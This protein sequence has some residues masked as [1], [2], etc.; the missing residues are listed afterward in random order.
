MRREWRRTDIKAHLQWAFRHCVG[1]WQVACVI[2]HMEYSLHCTVQLDTFG[3]HAAQLYS[4]QL[5]RKN[6]NN[7]FEYSFII[8]H[9]AGVVVC[10]KRSLVWYNFDPST[11]PPVTGSV[12][13][14]LHIFN[15]SPD[16]AGGTMCMLQIRTLSHQYQ[17]LLCQVGVL[18]NTRETP[19]TPHQHHAQQLLRFACNCC[20]NLTVCDV[21]PSG[22]QQYKT[23]SAPSLLYLEPICTANKSSRRLPE[24][25]TAVPACPGSA[26]Q[27]II[28]PS[29]RPHT[30]P[31]L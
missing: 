15:S 1:R 19:Q 26:V 7:W 24:N 10:C 28:L 5:K 18:N 27:C 12:W 17:Q 25:S 16:R 29:P 22:A 3:L 14:L 23:T 31:K 20:K 8:Q 9:E 11:T 6:N 2:W 13:T 21:A 30:K 4:M